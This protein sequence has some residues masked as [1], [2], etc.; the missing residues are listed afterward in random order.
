VI[1]CRVIGALQIKREPSLAE[2]KGPLIQ[3]VHTHQEN[4]T[5]GVDEGV[6]VQRGCSAWRPPRRAKHLTHRSKT[7]NIS[8]PSW[9]EKKKGRRKAERTSTSCDWH[10]VIHL[11]L[12]DEPGTYG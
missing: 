3:H 9:E 5:D 2:L 11:V 10:K 6:S 7:L 8:E 12:I 4:R 1:L